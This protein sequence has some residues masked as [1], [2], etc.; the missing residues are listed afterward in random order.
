MVR[1]ELRGHEQRPDVLA[2]QR[3]DGDAGHHGRVDAAREPHGRLVVA[4]LAEKVAHAAAGRLVDQARRV[5]IGRRDRHGR[6][7]G[8]GIE[9]AEILLEVA[10]HHDQPAPVVERTR[11]AVVDDVRSASHLIDHHQVLALDIGQ[12][13]H[14]LV[15]VGHGAFSVL[16]GVDRDDGLDR[17]VEVVR[18]AQVVAHHDGAA[19]TL[20]RDVLIAL[21]R[22]EKTH[23]ATGRD[24][25]LAD[26]AQHLAILDERRG[27]DGALAREPG[28]PHD[29]GGADAGRCDLD[30]RILAQLQERGLAQQIERGRSADRLLGENHQVGPLIFG[31]VDGIDDLGSVSFDITGR[32]VELSDCYLHLSQV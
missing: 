20:D 4:V 13:A 12:V 23:L 14:H 28:Q 2:P 24:V 7:V 21:R 19:V 6:V 15:P 5:G 10:H 29:G 25:F 27:A 3:L 8:L 9:D 11:R 22:N 16:A 31:S 18:T 1:R 30:Q 17:T 32:V 26:I